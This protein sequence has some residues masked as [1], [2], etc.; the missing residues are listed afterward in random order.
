MIKISQKPIS[1]SQLQAGITSKNLLTILQLMARYPTVFEFNTP[2][3]LQFDLTMRLNVI[4]ASLLLDQSGAEFTI[5]EDSMC[6]P[7]VWRLSGDRT[8][9]LWPNVPPHV[10]LNDIFINGQLYAFECG[11][12]ILVVFYKAILDSIGPN[13]FDRIF[14]DL[15][16]YNWHYHQN[17]SILV[18]E[19]VDYLPGDC[20]YFKNPDFSPSAPEWQGEN[21]IM[22]DDNL[23]FAHG[24]GVTGQQEIINELN[25][26]RIWGS[27]ISAYLTTHIISIESSIYR[28]YTINKPRDDTDP[29]GQSLLKQMI[30]GEVGSH[31]YLT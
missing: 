19:G 2:E 4:Q 5:L 28:A 22:L 18:H 23:F 12:A 9:E 31:T 26:N 25:D 30:L 29:L 13:N 17:L 14:P 15:F 6:N 11:T 27:M 16:L 3:D 24:I 8:F 10:A 20:L 21:A 7:R 1:V